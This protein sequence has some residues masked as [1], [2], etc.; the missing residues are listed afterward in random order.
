MTLTDICSVISFLMSLSWRHALFYYWFGLLIDYH[1]NLL[2]FRYGCPG[3]VGK[4]YEAFADFYDKH[5]AGLIVL[6]LFDKY[7]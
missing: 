7:E 4:E 1:L 3:L 5:F 6:M 2:Y